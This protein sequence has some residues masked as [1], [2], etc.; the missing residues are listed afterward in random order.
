MNMFGTADRDAWRAWLAEHY[1]IESEVWFVFPTKA[2]GEESISYNNAVEEALCFGWIDST[3]RSLDA[4]HKA[5][6]FTPRR[7]GSPYSQPNVERLREMRTQG[8]FMPDV[9]VAV[10]DLLDSSFE[11]PDD[12]ISEL[13]ADAVAWEFWQRCSEPY[14]RIRVAYVEAARKRPD[15]FER[16]LGNLVAK[17][18]Q[19]KLIRGYGGVDKYYW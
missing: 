17:T 19:G 15:E 16:R 5:R 6:R 9:E 11:F 10:G 13:R 4:M 2:A 12:I 14:R 1:K 7:P 18:W 3:N 8:R